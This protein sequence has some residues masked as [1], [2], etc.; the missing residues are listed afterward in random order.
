MARA[1]LG[2]GTVSQQI[3]PKPPMSRG[4][5][6]L[7]G[8]AVVVAA[9]P[10]IAGVISGAKNAAVQQATNVVASAKASTSPQPVKAPTTQTPRSSSPDPRATPKAPEPTFSYPGDPQCAITYRDRG[11]GSMTWTAA[12]TDAGELIT[13]ASDKSGNVYRHD[14]QVTPGPNAFAALVPLAQ[15]NDIGGVLY[16]GSTS[17]GCSVTP[18]Q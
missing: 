4:K 6:I 9:P 10:F 11:D 12:V 15:I 18:Q 5:K 16:V 13:H 14:V 8:V 2:R 3:Q 1:V 7:I 17:Y